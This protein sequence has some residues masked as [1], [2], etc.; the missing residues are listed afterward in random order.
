MIGDVR[1]RR[2]TTERKLQIIEDELCPRGDGF[3]CGSAAW[4][5]AKR[6]VSLASALE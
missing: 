5:C 6:S 3:L 4:S 1:R 2:W